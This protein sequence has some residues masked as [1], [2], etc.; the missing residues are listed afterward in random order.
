MKLKHA[1]GLAVV[2]FSS[3]SLGAIAEKQASSPKIYLLKSGDVIAE[4]R[5]KTP[6]DVTLEGKSKSMVIHTAKSTL[7]AE[8]GCILKLGVGTNSIS[9]RAEAIQSF[10]E[11]K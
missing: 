11:S 7:S 10:P 4:L 1:A 9:V 3:I 2:V 5:L 8:G 6:A